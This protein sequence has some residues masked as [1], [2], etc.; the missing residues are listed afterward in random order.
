[1]NLF[2]NPKSPH[3]VQSLQT[4]LYFHG[5]VIEILWIKVMVSVLRNFY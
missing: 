2:S 1:M 3:A 5:E 4:I